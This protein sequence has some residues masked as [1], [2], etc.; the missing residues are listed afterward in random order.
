MSTLLPAPLPL[1]PSACSFGEL[2]SASKHPQGTEI[3]AIT[4]S[5]MQAHVPSR[6][7]Q[8]FTANDALDKHQHQHAEAAAT[9]GAGSG[10]ASA[11]G[12]AAGAG[13]SDGSGD[14]DSGGDG[15]LAA[16]APRGPFD[17]YVIV[18]I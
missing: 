14:G 3:K 12:A 2:F 11:D 16:G 7:G 8:P 18:D 1:C 6:P 4:Y 5:N 17:L 15:A 9:A 10:S 13:G